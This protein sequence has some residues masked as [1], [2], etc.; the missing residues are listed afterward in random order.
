MTSEDSRPPSPSSID[1]VCGMT[2][3]PES[4]DGSFEYKHVTYYFCS[5]GCLEKFSADPERY[6]KPGP[7][8]SVTAQRVEV[9]YTCP[10]HP[11]ILQR[12]P[13]ACPKC[14]MALE[15]LHPVAAVKKTQWT[16]PMH[17]QIVRDKPGSCPI[18]GMTLE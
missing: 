1:P 4:A 18:C 14:G 13:G 3:V 6:L 16:C 9:E 11:K 7:A 17:A 5:Q 12:G 8:V 10:M 2:I 15:P